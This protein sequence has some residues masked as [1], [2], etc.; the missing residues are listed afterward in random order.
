[1]MSW[2]PRPILQ[3]EPSGDKNQKHTGLA[4]ALKRQFRTVM[5]AVTRRAPVPQPQTRRRG[6]TGEMGRSFLLAARNLLRPIA[7]LPVIS[8]ATA[9]LHDT[10]AWLHLWNW[11]ENANDHE[12][13]EGTGTRE[14]NHLSP[15]L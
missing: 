2:G 15:H 9:F 7:R 10:L 13:C 12:A 11:N 1:M 4:D 14:E 8:Q 3:Q 6:G 5:K